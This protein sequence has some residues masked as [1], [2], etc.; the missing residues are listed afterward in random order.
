MAFLRN[1]LSEEEGKIEKELLQLISGLSNEDKPEVLNMLK[2]TDEGIL[3]K[4]AVIN[5]EIDEMCKVAELGSYWEALWYRCGVNPE[6]EFSVLEPPH[7]YLPMPTLSCFELLKGLYIYQLYRN[8][9]ANSE[10]D[11]NELAFLILSANLGCFFAL[12][13]LCR[14]GIKKINKEFDPDLAKQIIVIAEFAAKLYW[15]PGY[16]LLATVYQ[17]LSAQPQLFSAT[18]FKDTEQMLFRQA[19]QALYIAQKLE[20]Y[21]RPM[22]N[23]AFQGKTIAEATENKFKTWMQAKIQLMNASNGLLTYEDA[24]FVE[25]KA[26]IVIGNIK[27][28]YPSWIKTIDPEMSEH[29]SLVYR[30]AV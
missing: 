23:N 21:S 2:S 1:T 12:N 17:E 19:L 11:L 8:S 9:A 28:S 3:L 4:L 22:I 10:S 14:E 29:S 18:N 13:A 16:I 20:N 5:P 30:K 26:D 24:R 6:G 25:R 27:C 15:T 7:A